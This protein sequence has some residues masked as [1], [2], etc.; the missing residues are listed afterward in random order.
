MP[1]FT[2]S[3]SRGTA[4]SVHST[5]RADSRSAPQPGRTS[6]HWRVLPH[7]HCGWAS[8]TCSPST[9]EIIRSTTTARRLRCGMP[10]SLAAL[11][12]SHAPPLRLR[13]TGVR[14]VDPVAQH[15]GSLAAPLRPNRRRRFDRRPVPTLRDSSA[16]P[17]R[18]SNSIRFEGASVYLH[19]GDRPQQHCDP[20]VSMRAIEMISSVWEVT[21]RWPERQP[22]VPCQNLA[23]RL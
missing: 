17:L 2:S 1:P 16:A 9:V 12:D 23:A 18:T 5:T 20:R 7:H 21:S 11:R 15:C 22:R 14:F 13:V 4:E 8:R 19:C 6:R 10:G 3:V